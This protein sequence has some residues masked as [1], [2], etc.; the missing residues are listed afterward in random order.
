VKESAKLCT[1]EEYQPLPHT[2]Q[3]AI[4][5]EAYRRGSDGDTQDLYIHV[6]LRVAQQLY[7]IQTSTSGTSG[8]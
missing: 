4:A 8:L 6:M 7:E 5:E 2:I 1:M 3:E